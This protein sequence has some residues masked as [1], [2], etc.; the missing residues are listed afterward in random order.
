MDR[1]LTDAIQKDMEEK[2]I[3]LAGPRQVGKTYLAKK[4]LGQKG[5]KYY[6]WDLSENREQILNKAFLDDIFVV[7]DELHKYERWK[8]F[9]K[10][11]Y[12]QYH[13]KLKV[14]VTGSARLDVYRRG[15]DS[16]FG[17]YF[18]FHLHPFTLGELTN[19]GSFV[20]PEA[21]PFTIKEEGGGSA[22]DKLWKWGGFPEPFTKGTKDF[23]KRWSLQR[24]EL[25]IQQEIRDL[26]H[27]QHLS[28]VE[29]LM[30]LLPKRVGSP[31]SINSLAG[32]VQVASNTI[33]QWLDAFSRLYIVFT[34]PPFT[35][36][37]QR[38][39]HKERKLYLWDWS[40]IEDEG[41]R[42]ENLVAS[43]LWKG[44]QYWKD[45]GLGDYELFFLRD[46]D[47]REVDF[48]IT[49]D[50]TPLFLVEAKMGETQVSESLSYFCNRLKVP[51]IQVVFK[52]GVHLKKE[53]IQVVSADRWLGLLP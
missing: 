12:D 40:Q 38:S 25:L 41:A 16:L 35:K 48:C 30:L 9:L 21:I 39:I 20:Q 47:R 45:L 10:G 33:R 24:R 26:T 13:E 37:I 17:R 34:I 19:P 36:K 46:R 7:L 1:Y 32:D 50:R 43:H 5:G 15:G 51:G 44:V 31:L 8:G 27:I 42:F 4:I 6:N 49:K 28:L 53:R 3:L 2:F 11:I 22:L 14:L 18:L 23:H 52:K 29:H